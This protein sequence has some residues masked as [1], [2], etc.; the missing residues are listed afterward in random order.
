MDAFILKLL[1]SGPLCA[2]KLA[3]Q[4]ESKYGC[5]NSSAR[6]SISRLLYKNKSVGKISGLLSKGENII[7]LIEDNKK[8]S[9]YDDLS[10][11]LKESEGALALAFSAIQERGGTIAKEQFPSGTGTPSKPAK[12]QIHSDTV[13]DRLHDVKLLQTEN[14]TISC[15]VSKIGRGAFLAREL[16]EKIILEYLSSWFGKINLCSPQKIWYR[17]L[18]ADKEKKSAGQYDFDLIGPTYVNPL[19]S[20]KNNKVVQGYVVAD[21]FGDSVDVAMAKCF[22]KKG[23][24]Y[25]V[26]K[27]NPKL[28]QFYIAYGF[29]P[30]AFKL[31]RESG[32]VTM[33][34]EQMFGKEAAKALHDMRNMFSGFLEKIDFT[35]IERVMSVLSRISPDFNNARGSILEMIT[36]RYFGISEPSSILELNQIW[37]LENG[38]KMEVDLWC[39]SQARNIFVEC[40][41]IQSGTSVD[42]SEINDWL[43][44][45][46]PRIQ[47]YKKEHPDK[48]N[49]AEKTLF[50]LWTTGEISEKSKLKINEHKLA[51]HKYE[52]GI[53]ERKDIEES[54][55]KLNAN[56]EIRV[57]KE[58]FP[59]S[60]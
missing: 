1:E 45:R 53:F 6:Q 47:K 59:V 27:N 30:E 21:V 32:A 17:F 31:L 24:A 52:I 18:R 43:E 3:E 48:F 4:L 11:I 39:Q 54:F 5:R 60:V 40:K 46:I 25:R 14:E 42:D 2:S 50:Y 51:T 13:Y 10:K 36:L 44:K 57:L 28:M 37:T 16:E 26:H 29:K 22:I 55:R 8:K 33:T 7:F 49:R 34:I 41:A 20:Y 38:D 12:K 35:E 56:K 58:H 15:T 23:S 9:F 19:K